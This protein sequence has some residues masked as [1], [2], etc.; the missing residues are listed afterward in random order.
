VTQSSK[1]VV[2]Q[3]AECESPYLIG[4]VLRERGF[5][6][7]ILRLD[8]G[9]QVPRNLDD[10]AGLV[11]MG[12]P[13]NVYEWDQYP[14]LPSEFLLIKSAIDA[15]RP[16]LGICLGSQLMAAALGAQVYKGFRREIGWHEI[17]LTEAAASDSLWKD[18]PHVFMGFHWHGDVFDLPPGGARLALSEITRNQAFV[19]GEKAYG[20]LFH[21]EVTRDAVLGMIGAF[22]EEV[23]D[24]GA[25]ARVIESDTSKHL[26]ELERIGRTVFGRWADLLE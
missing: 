16:V 9:D 25:D 2:L 26:V 15:N 18:L 13:Q 12:G 3:H 19:F 11:V 8:L 6:L 24:A 17:R 7:K 20:F 1:I 14:Y 10:A 23:A 22:P 5:T 4:D 21:L